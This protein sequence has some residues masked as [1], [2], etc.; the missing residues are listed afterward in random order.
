MRQ[1]STL[2]GSGIGLKMGLVGS[3]SGRGSSPAARRIAFSDLQWVVTATSD[4]GS[5]KYLKSHS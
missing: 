2:E 1:R 5:R 3:S 4:H